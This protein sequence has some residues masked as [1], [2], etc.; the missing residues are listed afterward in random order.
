MTVNFLPGDAQIAPAV[1]DQQFV[2]IEPGGP[3]YLAVWTDE[4][5]VLSGFVNSS[6]P[7]SGN[8]QDVYGQLLDQSGQ[9]VGDP[10]VIANTGQNQAKPDLA[11]N[12]STQSWLVVFDSQDPDWYFHDQVYGVRVAAD[13]NV[14]DQEPILLFEQDGN[15]GI[16]NADVASDGND[17]TIVANKF[18]GTQLEG[19]IFGRRLAGDG[20]LLELQPTLIVQMDLMFPDIA[21]ADNTYMIAAKGRTTPNVFVTRVDTALNP[22][23]STTFVGSCHCPGAHISSNGTEFMVVADSAY[24]ITSAGQNLDPGG[25][26]IGGSLAL[27]AHRDVTWSG[28][29]WSVGMKTTQSDVAVQRIDATGA[30]IDSQPIVVN[31]DAMDEQVAIAGDAGESVIVFSDRPGVDQ[32]IRAAHIGSNGTASAPVDVSIGLSRQS[33]VTTVDGPNGENLAVYLSQFSGETRILSQRIADDGTVLDPEPTVVEVSALTTGAPEVAWNGSV[34]MVTWG[35]VAK[36][37][38]AT[39]QVLDAQPIVVSDLPIGA[40]AAAG[41]TFIVGVF[42]YQGFNEP[43]NYVRFVRVGG[44]GTVLDATSHLVETGFAREMTAE[45]FGDTAIIA[46]AQYGRHDSPYANTQAAIIGAN[47]S[48]N[49]PMRVSAEL[50][51]TPDIAVNGNQALIVYNDYTTIHQDDIEGR[52]VLAN[53]TMPDGEF[54]IATAANEQIVPDASWIGDH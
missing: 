44:D 22:L 6:D 24:R 52:F 25:I 40:V 48:I 16:F 53:G 17:W 34:Y 21:Y 1:N 28:G 49:G 14:L 45:T 3:G 19:A 37:I 2:D 47:A 11:W 46:W 43:L 32:D 50:G 51:G 13:G 29:E 38:S 35:N 18:H 4:R 33:S 15:E 5:P 54:P 7:I 12:E 26:P 10:I 8:A 42:E 30:I 36:R 41:D 31:V 39:N 23:G 9:P 27:D 20:S